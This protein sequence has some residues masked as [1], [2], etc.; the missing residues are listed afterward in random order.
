VSFDFGATWIQASLAAPANPFAW[1]RWEAALEFPGRGYY[2]IWA[3]ATDHR[4]R[5]QPMVI[6]GW[7]P[8]GYLNNAMQRIAIRVI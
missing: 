1:Q 8:G 2:E 5:Q 4:G 6:P 3:R 7:N